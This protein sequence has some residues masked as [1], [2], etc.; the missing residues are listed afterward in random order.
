MEQQA[1][2]L[3]ELRVVIGRSRAITGCLEPLVL[4]WNMCLLDNTVS[5]II[6]Y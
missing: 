6:D 2:H 5:L 4:I 1:L 3:Y